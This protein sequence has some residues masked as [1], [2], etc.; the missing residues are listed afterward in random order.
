MPDHSIGWAEN[1]RRADLRRMRFDLAAQIFGLF[2]SA[3][4]LWAVWRIGGDF[5]SHMPSADMGA[6]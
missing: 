1:R 4:C 5:V 6:W 2:L 3:V